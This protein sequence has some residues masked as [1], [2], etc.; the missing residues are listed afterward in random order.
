MGLSCQAISSPPPPRAG[1]TGQGWR[2][3]DQHVG[4]GGQ[5]SH[6]SPPPCVT[7]RLVV[8]SLRGP[9]QSPV[10][11]FA[12]CVGPLLSVSRCGRCS[13]WCRF[14]V[15]GAPSLVCRG[16]AGCGSVVSGAQFPFVFARKC[17]KPRTMTEEPPLLSQHPPSGAI[18]QLPER[19]L[20]APGLRPRPGDPPVGLGL[21]GRGL[22]LAD[23]VEQARV[24]KVVLQVHVVDEPQPQ[25]HCP[26]LHGLAA[27]RSPSCQECRAA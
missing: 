22:T 15:R 26:Q 6:H 14:R 27:A 8:V 4:G 24:L 25:Q 11:A 21:T 12:C 19:P 16:C 1:G 23:P 10:L 9:G 18:F 3:Q 17:P 5:K 13:C 7:F 2:L 20:G